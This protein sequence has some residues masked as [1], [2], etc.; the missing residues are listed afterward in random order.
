MGLSRSLLLWGSQSK[1]LERQFRKRKFART[2]ISRFMPGERAEDAFREAKKLGQAGIA[3][4]ITK[5]GENVTSMDECRAVADHYLDALD[6]AKESGQDIQ[7]S[8][9]PTQLGLDLDPK[10][11]EKHLANLAEKAAGLGNVVWIDMEASNYVD[12]T[13]DLYRAVRS[14][15]ANV[16]LCLQ[17]YLHR[18]PEDLEGLLKIGGL[19]RLVKGAYQEPANVA[20]SSKKQ[21]DEQFLELS[22]T[23]AADG[24]TRDGARHGIATHDLSILASLESDAKKNRWGKSYEVQMLYGIRKMEQERLAKED[25][26]IRVLISYG[27]SWYPWYMRRLAERPANIGFVFRSMFMR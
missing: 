2:A 3:T 23:L 5:L 10:G 4:V 25:I 18:T 24:A 15:H 22:R 20:I 14:K 7:I 9:K 17:A 19:I 11:T 8:V 26:P 27:E 13:L 21:V 12:A 6:T 16:G 1:W